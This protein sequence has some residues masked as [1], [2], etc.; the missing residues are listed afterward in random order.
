MRPGLL[1]GP[2]VNKLTV[3]PS[4]S[5]P[6]RW[7][8]SP[9]TV[10]QICQGVL[11][12][13]Q[14]GARTLPSKGRRVQPACGCQPSSEPAMNGEQV[15][16]FLHV[17]VAALF[18]LLGIPLARNRIAPNHWYGFR[19]RQTLSDPAVWYPVNEMT[20]WWMVA[21]GAVTLPVTI[22]VYT[23]DVDAGLAALIDLIPIMLGTFGMI[24]HGAIMIR[25]L[26]RSKDG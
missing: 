8:L 26:N 15:I 11:L 1:K 7:I 9:E 25:Q 14:D 17:G 24:V 10:V 3:P 21:T 6:G 20:G 4:S 22:A 16:L 12:S 5:G 23:L 13:W 19:T 2:S 18:V